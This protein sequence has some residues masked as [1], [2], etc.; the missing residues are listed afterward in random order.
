M[1][2]LKVLSFLVEVLHP[3]CNSEGQGFGSSSEHTDF[4]EFP[5]I[6]VALFSSFFLVSRDEEYYH[7]AWMKIALNGEDFWI[8]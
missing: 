3:Q 1:T 5:R 6:S 2:S 7:L 4:S 8:N